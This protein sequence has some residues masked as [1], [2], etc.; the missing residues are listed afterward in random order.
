MIKIS[1]MLI[2][3]VTACLVILLVT[4]R[5]SV[6]MPDDTIYVTVNNTY[7]IEEVVVIQEEPVNQEELELLAH[8][9][10]AEAG[11]DWCN[12]E[13]LYSVGSV[14]LNRMAS[15]Y[16]PS[17]MR[18]VI[19]EKGQYECTWNGAIEKEP[20][21][22]A[23]RIAEDLLRNGSTLPSNVIF[24][25]QFEQGDGTYSKVQNMYFCYKDK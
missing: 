25:A 8:L 19:Y 2:C 7:V 17:T 23:Y 9:I 21:E 3:I 12:D 18:E 14:V 5:P 22:R 11:S 15:D 6:D 1:D 4:D 24:Q 13:M 10:F 16:F 20:N